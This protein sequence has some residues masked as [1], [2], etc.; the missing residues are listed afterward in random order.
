V[1]DTLFFTAYDGINGRELWKSDG[2]VE[3]TTLVADISSISYDVFFSPSYLTAVGDTLF[4]FAD[5]GVNGFELWKSDGTAAGTTSL[6][7]INVFPPGN[8]TAVGDTLFFI[9]LAGFNAG[10]LLFELWKSDG[11]AAGTTL[12]DIR[13]G[14]YG[15]DPGNL[16]AVGDTL[17]FRAFAGIDNGYELWKSDGTAAGTTLV[18]DIRSGYDSS[19]PASSAIWEMIAADTI[20]EQ[21]R[22]MWRNTNT[23]EL[24]LWYLDRQ[25]RAIVHQDIGA[26][27]S[28]AAI[29][30]EILFSQDFNGDGVIGFTSD[31]LLGMV[32][33]EESGNTKLLRNSSNQLF[34]QVGDADPVAITNRN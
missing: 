6:A 19:N 2:T 30:Q 15:S 11:T 3:G 1:N 23:N 21:N 24:R 25:W 34:T 9:A 13:S 8:L 18:A 14:Y 5:G 20:N 28:N 27:T 16:T 17:F 10:V 4:F 33:V 7:D 12:A 31:D 29:A 22:A 26:M 32:I